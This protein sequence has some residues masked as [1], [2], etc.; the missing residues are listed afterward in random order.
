MRSTAIPCP[1]PSLGNSVCDQT[2]VLKSKNDGPSEA[3]TTIVPSRLPY[4]ITA[5]CAGAM[6]LG[7]SSSLSHEGGLLASVHSKSTQRPVLQSPFCPQ[8]SCK[9]HLSQ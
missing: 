2:P 4:V 7:M 9:S 6:S 8:T 1:P 3:V 5:A